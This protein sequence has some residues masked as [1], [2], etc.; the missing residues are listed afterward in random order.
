VGPND[1]TMD[2]HDHG[3]ILVEVD[4]DADEK[5]VDRTAA[6]IWCR[7]IDTDGHQALVRCMADSGATLSSVSRVVVETAGIAVD[8]SKAGRLEYQLADG[9]KGSSPSAVARFE[10]FGTHTS[11]EHQFQVEKS[12]CCGLLGFQTMEEMRVTIK[13]SSPKMVV[14]SPFARV[15]RPAKKF[16]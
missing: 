8:D 4:R 2:V 15:Y 7:L 6:M 14:A 12:E 1:F 9:T 3:N 10:L 5:E 16:K 11:F 13:Q